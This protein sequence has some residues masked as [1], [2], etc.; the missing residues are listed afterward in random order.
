MAGLVPAIHVLLHRAKK[1][2]VDARDKPGHDAVRDRALAQD[3]NRQPVRLCQFLQ[4]HLR[5]RADVPAAKPAWVLVL[6][7]RDQ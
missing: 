7:I 1:K 4:R 2:D 6:T 3:L 5:P